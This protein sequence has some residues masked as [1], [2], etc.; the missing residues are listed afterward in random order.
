[1]SNE[2]EIVELEPYEAEEDSIDEARPARPIH[3]WIRIILVVLTVPWLMVFFVAIALIDPYPKG[4]AEKSGVHQ[5]LGLPP[6]SFKEVAG[7]PCPSCG[8]TTSFTLLMHADVWHSMQANFAG[9]ALAT[10]GVLFIPWAFASAFF[11]RFVFIRR[12]EV[13]VFRLAIVFL[14]L[15]FGRWGIVVIWD[16]FFQ[17]DMVEALT[18][19]GAM[20]GP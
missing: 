3:R 10:F 16:L 11:G 4:A 1:M 13:V 6:C 15:L 2:E 19:V 9:T 8:M 12:M 14:I 17:P 18:G 20:C 5:Q 7:I